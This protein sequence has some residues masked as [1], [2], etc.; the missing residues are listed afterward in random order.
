MG[1][2]LFKTLCPSLSEKSDSSDDEEYRE[3]LLWRRPLLLSTDQC[4]TC[5]MMLERVLFVDCVLKSYDDLD[6]DTFHLGWFQLV[7]GGTSLSGASMPLPL[8]QEG[9]RCT[10][11]FGTRT[12]V[13][14]EP[15]ERIP[16]CE[17]IVQYKHPDAY[18]TMQAR[19]D[20]CGRHVKVLADAMNAPLADNTVGLCGTFRFDDLYAVVGVP[21]CNGALRVPLPK[22]RRM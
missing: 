22:R 13:Q 4:V 3:V 19:I 12:I 16:Y 11:T 18:F 15:E 21:E 5:T 2:Y 6:R 7:H 9:S 8:N 20:V 1:L 14:C 17:E 10:F